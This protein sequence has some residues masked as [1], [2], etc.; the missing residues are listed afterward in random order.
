[1]LDVHAPH[2]PIYT[3]K[4][5][6]IHIATIVIGLLIA[7]GLEQGVEYVHHRHQAAIFEDHLRADLREEDWTYEFLLAYNREVI[8]YAERAVKALEGKVVLS[9][10]SLLVSAYRATQYK[11]RRSR[12]ATFDELI[13]TGAISLIRDPL[14]RDTAMQAYNSPTLDILSRE[15]QE[16]HYREAFRMSISNDVQRTLNKQCGDRYVR[17]G[18]FSAIQG[19]L[20]HPCTTGLSE[21]TVEEAVKALRS[22]P[23]L[24]GM[25]RLR[26]ADLE[27]RLVD[28]T[29][30]NRVILENL[31]A[32]AKQTSEP[33][34][35]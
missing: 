16:S 2:E 4:G 25:L 13:S 19:V 11:N 28:L 22:N 35:Q 12:R 17:P 32:I 31:R 34:V 24:V 29:N 27:T 7:V 8:T 26:I 30:N 3:W 9:N 20:D 33:T 21:Q 10:E 5:F 6:L 18:D 14:L 1:M 15:G 23:N